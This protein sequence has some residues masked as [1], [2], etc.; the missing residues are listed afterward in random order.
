MTENTKESWSIEK[1]LDLYG[2][3]RWGLGFFDVSKDGNVE[4]CPEAGKNN[5][6]VSIPEIISGLK[7]RGLEMPVLLRVG[8]FLN[9]RI[10]YLHDSFNTFIRDYN[11]QGTYQGV[12]PIKVNQQQQVVEHITDFGKQYHHGLEAGS[13]A[14][15]L[16]AISFLDDPDACLIC[17]GYKDQEFIDI[18]LYARKMGINCIFVVE[19]PGEL[20]L[21]LERAEALNVAPKIG[22]RIKLTSSG[23]GQWAA[24]GG[25]RSVFGLNM[26]Q[27]VE[28]IDMLRAKG[29]LDCLC[30]LHYHIG[31]QIP[32]IRDIRSS[33]QEACQVYRGLV[34]EGAHMR[35]LDLGGGLAVDYDGSHTNSPSSRN[36][37]LEEY[38]SDIV[39]TIIQNLNDS[40][41]PHP[42]IITESGRSTVAYYS[43]LLFNILDASKFEL[44]SFES[45][46][47]DDS[48]EILNNM[49]DV[50]NS[51]SHGNLQECFNDAV[52]YKDVLAQV[53]KQGQ[54]SLR[55]RA[56]GET[57]YWNIIAEI[58]EMLSSLKF[59]PAEMEIIPTL[60]SD[61]YYGNFSV[62]QSLPD[63]WAIE[64]LFPV[65]PVHRL[66]EKPERE[67]I[68]SDITCDCDGVIE[69]FIGHRNVR[70]S[71]PLHE[72]RGDEEYYLGVFLVGAYQET[73]GDLHNL[74]G[75]TNVVTIEFKE[76]GGYEIVRELE[77]DS[78]ADVL[79]YVEY[80][81]KEMIRRVRKMAEQAV[82]QSRITP[83]ERREILDTYSAGLRG[84]TYF[85]R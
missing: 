9:S 29:K 26:T 1:S 57:I 82:S 61:I 74:L 78:V 84:Y 37:T 58:G 34:E 76:G 24:S 51:L 64:Q 20:D 36:Y 60:L 45:D 40:G 43:I 77:G 68:I 10:K 50:F 66:N 32:N 85:E 44:V 80:D 55:E 42:V 15:L 83:Q 4:I 75:D 7:E 17:N 73:L 11:Y 81:P 70:K 65:M 59:V 62:F 28:A 39:D 67:G 3:N 8:D 71:L 49:K 47:S 48:P 23:G 22:V 38:C 25:D 41:V 69:R 12:Y 13:K 5:R 14:E 16:A 35:Y 79:S 46:L 54:I 19:I 63:I 53:F 21:I 56:I 18:G 72:L 6:K 31:S 33:V 2:V 52:Y 30:L 27:V